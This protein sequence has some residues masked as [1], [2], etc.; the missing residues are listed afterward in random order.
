M[1]LQT[2]YN[3]YSTIIEIQ[4]PPRDGEPVSIQ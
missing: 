4:T 3:I 1:Q 2:T